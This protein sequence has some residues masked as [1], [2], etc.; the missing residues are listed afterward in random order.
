MQ[1]LVVLISGGAHAMT[2]C[3]HHWSL[4]VPVQGLT[5][6]AQVDL[7]GSEKTSKTGAEGH[8]LKEAN[9]INK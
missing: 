1:S 8:R 6:G 3:A 4:V 7:A 9:T 5:G 2:G